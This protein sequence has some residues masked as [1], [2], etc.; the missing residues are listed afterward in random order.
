MVIFTEISVLDSIPEYAVAPSVSAEGFTVK[1]ATGAEFERTDPENPGKGQALDWCLTTHADH[2][3]EF[4]G[5]L[6]VDADAEVDADFLDEMS[7]SLHGCDVVQAYYG[8]ANPEENWRTALT[9]AGFS[10]MNH[11]RPG[12]RVRLGGSAPL[13][14]R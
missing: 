13:T 1:R 14:G 8:V 7:L 9:F 12:G 11:V 6:L 10:L 2:L 3:R 5:L 4:D